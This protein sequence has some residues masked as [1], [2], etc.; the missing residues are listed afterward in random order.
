MEK[1]YKGTVY[2]CF[3][4]YAVQALINMFVPLLFITLSEQYDI[5]LTQ[6]TLMITVNSL[7]QLTVDM[8]SALFMDKIGYR[9]CA[10]MAHI[11][12]AAGLILLTILPEVMPSPLM[13]LLI[14][15]VVYAIGG[16]I[17]EVLIS[18]V[19]EA[20]PT[21]N[22]EA[23]MSLLHSFFCWGVVAVV[24]ISTLFF[25]TVGIS[26]WKIMAVLW[27]LLPIGNAIAF[28]RVP[29]YDLVEEGE[30][31]LSLKELF[32]NKL[33]WVLMLLMFCAGASE[34]SVSQWASTFA[35]KGLGVSKTL[36][37]LTGI[38][39]FAIFMGLARVFYSKYGEKI[40]LEKF[41]MGS[42]ILC[43]ISYLMISLSPWPVMGLLGCAVCG[44]SVGILWPGTFSIGSASI[45]NGGTAMF[46]L[47]ALAGD[48]GCGSGPTF[49]G[50]ISG[51]LNDN[52]HMG[53]LAAIVFP[54]LLVVG[55]ILK[56]RM[57][58]GQIIQ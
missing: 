5:S 14:S 56:I 40:Q 46:A 10:V 57:D 28:S 32:F 58:K 53:I 13:G 51:Y 34:T 2:A 17:L 29:I 52:L 22:K 21:K 41:I 15:V 54:I 16:G 47:F 55:C 38:L 1:E 36:G 9:V 27:S 20:C 48:L 30:K 33:F 42:G 25:V 6:I 12:A 26:N 35:E 4:G 43:I 37:D 39:G 24:L 31:G 19:V 8:L 45:K 50:T 3:T 44:L 11:F 49:V 23:M 18:P 7:V